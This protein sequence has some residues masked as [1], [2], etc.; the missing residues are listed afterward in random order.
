MIR[1]PYKWA[2]VYY[3]LSNSF[4][5]FHVQYETLFSSQEFVHHT[6]RMTA[7]DPMA[8]DTTVGATITTAH[9]DKV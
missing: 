3:T 2:R 8:E 4:H 6:N 1:G 7:G 5:L 9:A